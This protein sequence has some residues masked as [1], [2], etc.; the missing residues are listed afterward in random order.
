[1]TVSDD[2][3]ESLA[4]ARPGEAALTIGDVLESAAR[5]WGERIAIV[6][7]DHRCTYTE[8]RLQA[9]KAAS[10]F[11]GLGIRK[12]DRIAI[13]L[14]NGMD[15]AVAFFGVI[16]AGAVVVPLNMVL[17]A[18]ELEYQVGHSGASVLV[19]CSTYRNRDY[20]AVARQ[21]RDAV[22]HQLKVVVADE[23][24]GDSDIASWVRFTQAASDVRLPPLDV[25]DPA[26]MMYTSG[27]TGR[28]KGAVHTHRF[29]STLFGGIDRLEIRETDALLLFLPLFHIYA[30]VA[31]MILMIMAGARVILMARFD[32]AGSLRLIQAERATIMYGIPT[33]YIDQLNDPAIDKTDFSS[34]R[35]ALTPL[36]YDLCQKVRAKI[37]TV[38]LN[39]YGMTE[40]AALTTVANL[41]DP[42]EIAMR[43]VGRPLGSMQAKIVDETTG[44]Q[45]P[46]DSPGAL[47]MRGP[48]IMWKYHEQPQATAEALDPDGW[49]S[50]GDLASMDGAGNITFIGR[51]G[52]GYRVGGELVD[53]VEVESAIQSHPAVLRAAALGVPD[54]RLG[55]V[56][57]AWAQVRP[58]S[59]ATEAELRAH[60][61]ALLASFKVPRQ[62]R[63]IGEL[64]TT[65]SG[66]VQKFRLRLTLTAENE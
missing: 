63:L 30:L 3:N 48:S 10:G 58:G 29:I 65:P 56:G 25:A 17:S 24:S 37:G 42:P 36:S 34:L 19:V 32:A 66:K 21:V 27:T 49:F 7:G 59:T 40:T 12:G 18:A 9:L 11:A 54:E 46:S 2:A 15:W 57:Y 4:S 28:P 14:P 53:P 23:D 16:Y 41:D 47:V 5:K 61:A 35:F 8:L 43:T 26:I 64:P 13:C 62:I 51:R 45:L 52:D 60:A 20:R 6:D 22:G 55:E 38:C 31:G 1:M 33:T 39:P 44:Q 50:T